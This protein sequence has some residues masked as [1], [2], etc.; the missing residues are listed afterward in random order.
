[1]ARRRGIDRD[2]VIAAGF[3]ILGRDG[4]DGVTLK[5]V[6]DRL[7]VRSPSLYSHVEGIGLSLIHI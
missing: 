4:T 2:D 7:E 5:A 1:M 6:A 3:A